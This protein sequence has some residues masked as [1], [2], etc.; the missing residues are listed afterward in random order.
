M[1]K[2]I[3]RLI[4]Y[5]EPSIDYKISKYFPKTNI[6]PEEEKD[7]RVKIKSSS[8]VRLL[9]SEQRKDGTIPFHPYKKW[10]GTH[11]VLSAL[12]DLDYPTKDLSIQPLIEQVYHWIMSSSYKKYWKIVAGKMRT[13]PCQIGNALYYII[14]LGYYDVRVDELV[15]WLK[16]WQWEDGGWNCDSKP[17]AKV[18]SFIPTTLVIRGLNQYYQLTRDSEVKT[19]IQ[20]GI[21]VLIE[22]QL[23][24]RLHGG[25]LINEKFVELYYPTYYHYN[26][27][28]GLLVLS[29]A[30]YKYNEKLD[31][32]L[33]ILESKQLR[34]G[35][36]PA[37]RK[38]YCVTQIHKTTRSLVD[39]GVTS[40]TKMNEF[41][42]IYVLYIL[43]H[44]GRK[45]VSNSA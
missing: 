12:A 6:S 43:Q 2:I 42:T 13:H 28:L 14:K 8:R 26:I 20:R 9:L 1:E 4:T 19:M 16:N 33:K 7:F 3:E 21:Q 29:E 41:V 23:C 38:Y 40:R 32:A 34:N 15:Q 31:Y 36:W 18:S 24:K 11:W 10:Y 37:E 45:L 25:N 30:G 27:L 35:G 39:W 44:F 22:R 17:K 5:N